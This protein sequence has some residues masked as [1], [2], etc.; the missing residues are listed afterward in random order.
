MVMCLCVAPPP[1]NNYLGQ[2]QMWQFLKFY[3]I[4]TQ[5][6]SCVRWKLKSVVLRRTGFIHLCCNKA[7][8]F[9]WWPVFFVVVW[10]QSL[11]RKEHPWRNLPRKIRWSW[12]KKVNPTANRKGIQLS[13]SKSK[14]LNFVSTVCVIPENGH[15]RCLQYLIWSVTICTWGVNCTGGW[16]VKYN[17]DPMKWHHQ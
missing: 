11:I 7:I 13:C 4:I 5:F 12:E 6:T 14:L 15:N 10:F 16:S 3:S 2:F 9:I 8:I 17:H 1:S